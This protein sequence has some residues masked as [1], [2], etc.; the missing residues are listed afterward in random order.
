MIKFLLTI[1]GVV[2]VLTWTLVSGCGKREMPKSATEVTGT[3]PTSKAQNT[4]TIFTTA[5]VKTTEIHSDSVY[6]FAEKD[7]IHAYG[8]RVDFYNDDG[9]WISLLTADSGVIRERTEH[10]KV[11]GNVEVTTS[12]SIHLETVQLTWDPQ[13]AKIITDKYVTI[14]QHG[15][16]VRGYGMEADADLT[17]IV[18]KREIT[19]EIRDYERVVDS[20]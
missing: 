2:L 20:L 8:V 16:I 5:G 9:E 12:D 7:S 6:N 1:S 17:N 10:L 3:F 13:R 4:V 11:F 15:D 19:G 18:L 14:D